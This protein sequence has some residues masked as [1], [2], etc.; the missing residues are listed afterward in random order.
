MDGNLLTDLPPESLPPRLHTLSAANNRISQF[1]VRAIEALRD[2]IGLDL[3]GNC[4]QQLPT[5]SIRTEDDGRSSNG[6]AKVRLEK[7]D[8]GENLIGSLPD[9]GDS[10]F[11]GS[12]HIRDLHLDYNRIHTIPDS[13]LRGTYVA[14]LHLAANGLVTIEER[15]FHS[16]SSTLVYLDLNR[17]KLKQVPRALNHLKRLRFLHLAANQIEKLQ[18]DGFANFGH[19]LQVL[20]LNENQLDQF[21]WATLGNCTNLVELNLAHNHIE[22]VTSAMF[23]EWAQDLEVL[24]LK[25]NHLIQL[26]ARLFRFA[27]K[28]RELNLS[29]NKLAYASEDALVDAADSLEKIEINMAVDPARAAYFPAASLVKQLHQLQWLSLDYNRI[30]HLPSTVFDHLHRLVYLSLE[31]NRLAQV[32]ASTGPLV[33]KSGK[34]RSLRVLRLTHNHLETLATRTFHSFHELTNVALDHNRIQV[35]ESL[36]F[37]HL[38]KLTHIGM[39]HN[40]IELLE[41]KS[42]RWLPNLVELDLHANRLREFYWDAVSNCTNPS[43]PAKLNIS[44]NL[45]GELSATDEVHPLSFYFSVIDA[46]HNLLGSFP[47]KEFFAALAPKS[48]HRLILHHNRID[49]LEDGALALACRALQLLDLSHNRI[50]EI[51]RD[52]LY[53][54]TRIQIL[55][56][57]DNSIDQLPGGTF[58]S[59]RKLRIVDLSA[60]RLRTLPSDVFADTAVEALNLARNQLVS[61]PSGCLS[62]ISATLANLDLSYNEIEHLDAVVLST[63]PHL[64]SL[65]LAH[66]R[67][68]LLP[69]NLFSHLNSLLTLDLSFNSIR[70]NFKELF[71]ELQ[72]VK[73]LNLA[74]IGLGKWPSMPLPR[75]LFLNLSSN[76]L[77]FR[78][79]DQ[80]PNVV[81]RLDSLRSLDLSHNRLAIVPSFLWSAA[82]LLK[83]VDL[84][85]NA[86]R[87]IHRDS[88][89]GLTRLQTLI[90]RPLPLLE[91]IESDSFQHLL[92]LNKLVMQTWAGLH[93]AHLL[94]GLRG[95]KTLSVDV[96]GSVLSSVHFD[97][98]GNADTAPK[99]REVEI[100]GS[101]LRIVHGD[102]FS[103]I[104]IHSAPECTV[105]LMV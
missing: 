100:T 93:L 25:G 5:G 42:F 55:L 96:R 86:I 44:D 19:H 53:G 21:P 68:T 54:A 18:R 35:V 29:F 43:V 50:K 88:F 83:Q 10:I 63:V 60:N 2:L 89:T 14:R 38:P 17:N 46:S 61:M 45:I 98:I 27:P 13:A 22:N 28:L 39:A 87:T 66:N 104:N 57:S 34:L 56:L 94:S 64:V 80:V 74:G 9:D 67:L 81:L 95:L 77:E 49:S 12:V 15:A 31:G 59:L 24:N 36:T 33:L 16:L 23:H 40:R 48:L 1:P 6:M 73:K 102:I 20:S 32:S 79:L 105:S 84:S 52:A 99:L 37:D 3:R 58:A 8:L 62:S 75:V 78:N 30:T 82:P 91:T 51:G 97:S 47:A 41:E 85:S 101:Q 26:P 69:D 65:N 90:M 92:F 4:I 103:N 70:A 76:G 11:N 71:H 72:H 7:L